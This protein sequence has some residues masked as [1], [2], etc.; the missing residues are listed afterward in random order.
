MSSGDE[1]Q[2]EREPDLRE[3]RVGVRVDA[4]EGL[5]SIG[6]EVVNGL[7][8]LGGRIVALE[9]GG[10]IMRKLDPNEEKLEKMTLAGC[11]MQVIMDVSGIGETEASQEHDRLYRAGL[12]L[13][14]PYMQ[15]VGR[16]TQ[17]V[18]SETAR[19]ELAQG[20]Q[21]LKWVLEI[22]PGN[23]S[24]WWLIGKAEQSLEKT[25]E[26]W[27]AFGHAYRLKDNNADTAREYMYECLKL[28]KTAPAIAAARHAKDLKP[29]DMGLV[30]NLALALLIGGEL[31]EAAEAIE[32]AVA[33][34]PDDP[35]NVN[36]QQRIA[37]V[38][39]GTVPQPRN[40]ADMD[41]G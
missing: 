17:P 28:G 32:E 6:M 21:L 23:G 20:I 36:L 7:I 13:I 14:N 40:L 33:G 22:N 35:I 18:D 39:A 25:E 2:E 26:A 38:R 12:D 8:N 3:F 29:D 4:V 37:E 34:A 11:D 19:E 31:E 1:N 24:A 30:A 15:I 10:A 27:E 9:G 41:A 16:E 5:Q